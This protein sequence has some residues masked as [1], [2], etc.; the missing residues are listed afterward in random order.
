M[1]NW[2]K[3]HTIFGFTTLIVTIQLLESVRAWLWKKI[4]GFR[5]WTGDFDF[6][7]EKTKV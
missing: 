2:I 1:Y 7:V 3:I 6:L 5:K 4:P